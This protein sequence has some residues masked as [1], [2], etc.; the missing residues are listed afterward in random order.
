M[1]LLL[2]NPMCGIPPLLLLAAA[3]AAEAALTAGATRKPALVFAPLPLLR[4][5]L[6]LNPPLPMLMA[7]PGSARDSGIVRLSGA[8][9]PGRGL[10]WAL[11]AVDCG[12][13]GRALL[14]VLLLGPAPAPIPMP[15][16]ARPIALPL[17][18]CVWGRVWLWLLL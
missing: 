4:G 10:L 15:V 5:P 14:T 13:L 6:L 11:V 16:I 7:V 9:A 12:A 3:A 17:W 8:V 18:L 1:G 2:L